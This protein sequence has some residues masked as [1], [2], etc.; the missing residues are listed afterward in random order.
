[1]SQFI[2]II[3]TFER[4]SANGKGIV[5]DSAPVMLAV[6]HMVA[7][8][9]Q[10]DDNEI[11]THTMVDMSNGKSFTTGHLSDEIERAM[12]AEGFCTRV[13]SD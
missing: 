7:V 4:N 6:A 13:T 5:Q 12:T 3:Q 8:R 1:M 9:P 10:W 2:E 11:W